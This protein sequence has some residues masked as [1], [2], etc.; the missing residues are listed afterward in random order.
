MINPT[1]EQYLMQDLR[2]KAEAIRADATDAEQDWLE[3][4]DSL[5]D[6]AEEVDRLRAG[7]DHMVPDYTLP[8]FA[9]ILRERE[10]LRSVIENAPHDVECA[11]GN[12]WRDGSTM[13][14]TCWKSDAL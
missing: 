8:Q 5:D 3:V 9:R 10:H 4:A 1:P 12:V 6:A 13:T 7:I 11:K 2:N 14:C